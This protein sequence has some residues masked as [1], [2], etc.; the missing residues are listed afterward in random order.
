MVHMRVEE[1][2]I[3]VD[4]DP[5]TFILFM[6]RAFLAINGSSCAVVSSL[7]RLKTLKLVFTSGVTLVISVHYSIRAGP[8]AMPP[9][10][11]WQNIGEEK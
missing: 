8:G 9:F 11:L 2:A 4:L 7:A 1:K 5:S 10:L 6:Y 3:A